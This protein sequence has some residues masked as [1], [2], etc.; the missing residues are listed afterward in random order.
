[1]KVP[2]AC[3]WSTPVLFGLVLFGVCAATWTAHG[4]SNQPFNSANGV[5]PLPPIP[6]NSPD[7][8]AKYEN[9]PTNGRTLSEQEQLNGLLRQK[10]LTGAT[11]LLLKVAGE[12]RAEI[13]AH[14]DG[15]RAE[16]E[17]L[18]L[19][20]KIARLIRDSEEAGDRI[21]AVRA[22]ARPMGQTAPTPSPSPSPSAL[23][24][25]GAPAGPRQDAHPPPPASALALN[26]ASDLSASSANPPLLLADAD[27][28]VDLAQQMKTAMDKS[29][30]Y[31]L[32]LDTVRH[33]EDV[34]NLARELQKQLRQ[35]KR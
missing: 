8:L 20:E 11:G 28:L 23:P 24:P 27:K 5:R 33:A 31:V 19:I 14:P 21:S 3:G 32:S 30:Q 29:D 9:A 35:S 10:Q 17:R 2:R 25:N 13:A 16:T 18:K 6:G 34:E 12:L 7:P 15:V 22:S 4:Q 26:A 1:M